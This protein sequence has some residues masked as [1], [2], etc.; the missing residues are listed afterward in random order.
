M[1]IVT[2][3][4]RLKCAYLY[5][6]SACIRG[7]IFCPR[8]GRF[9]NRVS[10]ELKSREVDEISASVSKRVSESIRARDRWPGEHSLEMQKK[11]NNS[12]Y[13]AGHVTGILLIWCT[14]R[15]EIDWDY[16][17]PFLAVEGL[18][19]DLVL[20]LGWVFDTWLVSTKSGKSL[21]QVILSQ[22]GQKKRCW[23]TRVISRGLERW[24]WYWWTPQVHSFRIDGSGGRYIFSCPRSYL[25]N[26]SRFGRW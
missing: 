5:F 21:P 3:Q 4:R 1:K 26:Q 20:W 8:A 23:L 12:T 18:I 24:E 14:V 17:T 13:V 7:E 10:R 19:E 16:L 22:G 6:L 2:W 11:Q 15:V 9:L 25:Q